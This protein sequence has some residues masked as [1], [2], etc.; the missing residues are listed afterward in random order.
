MVNYQLSKSI[1]PAPRHFARGSAAAIPQIVG[2]GKT[3][4]ASLSSTV[5]R[6]KKKFGSGRR[7]MGTETKGR[8][9]LR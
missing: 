7:V 4:E 1:G 8:S 9:V 5:G 2:A 3:K 6:Y